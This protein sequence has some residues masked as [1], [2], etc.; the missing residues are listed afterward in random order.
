MFKIIMAF[1]IILIALS[2]GFFTFK[3]KESKKSALYFLVQ[4]YNALISISNF[5]A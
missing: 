1:V 5:K 3:I 4:D 2:G